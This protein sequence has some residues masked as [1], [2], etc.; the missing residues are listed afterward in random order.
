MKASRRCA[1]LLL[2]LT[3]AAGAATPPP[4]GPATGAATVELSPFVVQD[5]AGG[6]YAAQTLAGSRLRQDLRDLGASIQ[7]VTRDLLEDLGATGLD[8]LLQFTTNTEVGGIG[9]NFTGAID[10]G[11][12][13]VSTDSARRGGADGATRVRGLAAPSRA[14]N[15]FPTGIPFDS[16]NADRVDLSRGANSFLFG[17]GSPAGLINTALMKA[18]F[19]DTAELATRVGSGGFEPSYRGSFHLNRILLRDTLAVH[20]AALTDRT[21]YRQRPTHKN[22][23]RQ[24]AALTYQPF[25]RPATVVTAHLERGRIR[26]NTPDVLL[27]VQNLDTFLHDPGA[28]RVSIAAWANLQRFAHAEG[29][30]QAQWNALPPAERARYRVRD[31]PTVNSLAALP[32]GAGAYGLVYDGTNGRQPAFAYTDQY[33]AAD[34]AIRDPFFGPGRT[35]KGAPASPYHGNRAEIAGTGWLDQGFTNLKT[36]DFSREHLGWDNDYHSR[37]FVNLNAALEQLLWGGR[38]GF[39][40]AYDHEDQFQRSFNA[41]NF[42]NARVIFDIQETLWLPTDPNYRS[43]GAAAPQTNPNYGRPF[44]LARGNPATVDTRRD[45]ARFTGFVRHDFAADRLR[46]SWLGRLLGRHTLTALADRSTERTQVLSYNLSSFADPDPA[47]HI[48][49]ANARVTGNASRNVPL[50]VYVG[51]PQPQAFT[52]PN[53]QLGDFVLTPARYQ[54][55]PPADYAIRKLTWNLGP[56]ST[57]E[58]LGLDVRANGNEGFV[59]ADFTPRDVPN[60]NC[61]AQETRVSSYA[62]NG[63]S[64]FWDDLLVVNTGY[65]V[66]TV[67]NW[68]NVEPPLVGRDQIPD[69][70]PAAFR[71]TGGD[72]TR[73]RSNVFGYGGVLHWPRRLLPLPAR[74]NVS[75]HYNRS[76]NFVPAPSR[77]DE[78]R[79]PVESPAGHSRDLGFTVEGWDR[80]VVARFN[81]YQSRLLRATSSVSTLFHQTNANAFNHYGFLNA[82]LRRLDADGDGRIDEAALAQI[83]VDATTGLTPEGLTRDQA[84]RQSWPNLARAREAMAAIAPYLTDPLKAAVNYRMLPDG[85]VQVSNPGVITDTN[86]LEARGF[87]AELT[88]NPSPRWRITFNAASQ[89]TILTNVA[90]RL[91][92]VLDQTWLPHL[93]NFGDLD[94]NEPAGVVNG[95]T[96]AQQVNDRLQEYFAIKGQEGRPQQEQRRWRF[97]LV[98]RH[99]FGDGRLRGLS[100]GGALRWE[101]SYAAGYPLRV[102][103]RGVI[104][105][106]LKNPWLAPPQTSADLF[107]GYQRRLPGS[108]NWTLQLNV[109]NLQ[110]LLSDKVSAVRYQPDGGV[111]RVRFDPPLQVYLTNTLRL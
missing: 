17:L 15:Y 21:R 36:F 58:N 81:W 63:Q 33:R 100:V 103:A 68:L 25:S 77:V 82:D 110:N 62:L 9:G 91:T 105:P 86:D 34:Y 111:A 23:D 28:G 69:V 90:P 37:D 73:L 40:L 38:G 47:L 49:N 80:K 61:Q 24:Y 11:T 57:N 46:G 7:V 14:R 20:A 93:A 8:E 51:P 66:D 88:V 48:G 70:S 92:Q 3:L 6:Y 27:P 83:P 30:T 29:P 74:A 42:A 89:V 107:L 56:D 18:R 54:L 72:L 59:W 22:D 50:M 109:R 106:D 101:D 96:L 64:V 95:P 94:W 19:R 53:F 43:T 87:E 85:T 79:R 39:E 97:N 71:A 32:W 108:R 10:G 84:A 1:A 65:R 2:L 60:N 26:G 76:E 16:Y 98:G 13:D 67:R 45:A 5:R 102:D 4:P 78:L 55:R 31:T 41:I 52:D 44:V 12:G 35:S 75:L 99:A 104:Q